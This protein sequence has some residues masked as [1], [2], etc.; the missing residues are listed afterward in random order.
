MID[1]KN[2]KLQ[3]FYENPWETTVAAPIRRGNNPYEF[4]VGDLEFRAKV[5][6]GDT[7]KIFVRK[8]SIIEKIIDLFR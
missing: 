8:K 7:I 6:N 3:F 1:N 2:P 5:I 4:I